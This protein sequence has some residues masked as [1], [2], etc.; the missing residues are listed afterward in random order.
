MLGV[1]VSRGCFWAARVA[2]QVG[3]AKDWPPFEGKARTIALRHIRDHGGDEATRELRARSCWKAAAEQWEQI[4]GGK[5]TMYREP[6]IEPT[7]PE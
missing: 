2:R 4:R 6:E 3:T 5:L 1:A 7:W